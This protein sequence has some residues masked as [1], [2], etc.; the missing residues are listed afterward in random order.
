MELNAKNS[1]VMILN[2]LFIPGALENVNER[3]RHFL[4][5]FSFFILNY[6]KHLENCVNIIIHRIHKSVR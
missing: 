5:S 2:V 3:K 1:V 4:V 6:L